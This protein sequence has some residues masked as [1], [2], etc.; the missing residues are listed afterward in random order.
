MG[1]TNYGTQVKSV[2]FYD[3]AD[4]GVVNKRNVLVQEC[5]IYSG[6]YLTTGVGNDVSL[7]PLVCVIKGADLA[8]PDPTNFYQ[9][10]VET[11]AAIT[12]TLDST[13]RF[14]ILRW[15]YTGSSATDYMD[16]LAVPS[17]SIGVNDLL[18]GMGNFGLGSSLLSVEYVDSTKTFI[19]S[20]AST[21]EHNLKVIPTTTPSMSVRINQGYIT[22]GVSGIFVPTQTYGPIS[23]AG[24]VNSRIDVLYVDSTGTLQKFTGAD[25]VTPVAPSYENKIVLAEIKLTG[26]MSQITAASIRDTRLFAGAGVNIASIFPSMT[27]NAYKFL[28]VKAD[29]TGLEYSA[30]TYA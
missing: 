26:G 28:R 5:G 27:G 9:L 30:P 29:E 3:P 24:L 19:R 12:L 10:R 14:V 17:G 2:G 23:V 15:A 21:S 4:S 25:A 18:V 11:K 7:S 6:G 22:Y 16:V 13:N 1:S 20:E 8:T